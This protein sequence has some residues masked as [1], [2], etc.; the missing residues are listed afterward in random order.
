MKLLAMKPVEFTNLVY[1]IFTGF[2]VRAGELDEFDAIEEVARM[3]DAGLDML[4]PLAEREYQYLTLVRIGAT[5]KLNRAKR[6]LL[7]SY[8]ENAINHASFSDFQL[9]EGQC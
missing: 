8:L 5:F 6:R 9:S 7:L 1:Q 4:A 3:E 2:V